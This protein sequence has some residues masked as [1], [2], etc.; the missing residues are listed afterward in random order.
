MKAAFEYARSQG[1]LNVAAAGNDNTNQPFYPAAF[2]EYV[3]SVA[4]TD[5]ND[6]KYGSSNYGDWMESSAPPVDIV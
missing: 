5:Q 6:A 1:V 4:K 3:I 2:G